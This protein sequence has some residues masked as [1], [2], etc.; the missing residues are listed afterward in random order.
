MYERFTLQPFL[1]RI[2]T[3]LLLL[4]IIKTPAPAQSPQP[5]ADLAHTNLLTSLGDSIWIYHAP[6]HNISI[7]QL[8]FLT[9]RKATRRDHY[10]AP[11]DINKKTIL[12]FTVTNSS[13]QP[14]SAFL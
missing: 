14:A 1:F 3:L 5:A 10:V 7:D 2:S 6:T 8:P 4:L 9:Y 11:G 12:R 13:D